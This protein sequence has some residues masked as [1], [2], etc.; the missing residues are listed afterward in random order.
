MVCPARV[1]DLA[2]QRPAVRPKKQLPVA[3]AVAYRVG[4]QFVRGSDDVVDLLAGQPGLGGVRRDG[5]PQRVQEVTVE[6]L[7][8]DGGAGAGRGLAEAVVTAHGRSP[9]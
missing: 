2:V 6:S 8:Q 4:C 1:A 9:V 5:R 3:G 7:V